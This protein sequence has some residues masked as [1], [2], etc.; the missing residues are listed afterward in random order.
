MRPLGSRNLVN[1]A[2]KRSV[3]Q[4]RL[5]DWEAPGPFGKFVG[6]AGKFLVEAPGRPLGGP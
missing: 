2:L 4:Q 1:L 3:S 5:F 6:S